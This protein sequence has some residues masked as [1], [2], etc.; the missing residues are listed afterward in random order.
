MILNP[1]HEFTALVQ[2]HFERLPHTSAHYKREQ[3]CMR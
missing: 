2:R 1:V 3:E